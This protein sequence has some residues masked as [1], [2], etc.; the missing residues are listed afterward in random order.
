M[1]R[2]SSLGIAYPISGIFSKYYFQLTIS[3]IFFKPIPSP[4]IQPQP[5]TGGGRSSQEL[6]TELYSTI[7]M[8]LQRPR[9]NSR[10]P[11]TQQSP[12]NNNRILTTTAESS[13]QQQN[14][15]NS[16]ER[17]SAQDLSWSRCFRLDETRDLFGLLLQ[18]LI[19]LLVYDFIRLKNTNWD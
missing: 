5:D 11:A 7:T 17:Q 18:F 16:N 2:P 13:Q 6:S 3:G 15:R 4:I 14:P 19:H 12:C 8:Q 10:V 9:N 1:I